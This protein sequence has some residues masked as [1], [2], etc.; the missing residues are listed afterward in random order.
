L[1]PSGNSQYAFLS[2]DEFGV[3]CFRHDSDRVAFTRKLKLF[4]E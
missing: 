4:S 3:A 2:H 1:L